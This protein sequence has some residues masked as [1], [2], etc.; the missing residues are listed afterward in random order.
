MLE[1][2]LKVTNTDSPED[3]VAIPLLCDW[4][5]A[6]VLFQ[7]S[8][9][10]GDAELV[11]VLMDEE[12]CNVQADAWA[13]KDDAW[14]E[15]RRRQ[16]GLNG[17][18]YPFF[19]PEARL[20]RLAKWDEVPAYSFC[21][22]LSLSALYKSWA[23]SFG[24]DY[25]EQGE[26]FE[27]LTE[28]SL[29]A[30]L[31]T[32]KIHR[33]GW[34]HSNT[35]NLRDIVDDVAARL[36]ES[37]GNVPKWTRPQAKEAGLDI[38][39]YRPYHDDRGSLPVYLMQCSSGRDFE[40]KLQTPDLKKWGRIVEFTST[41]RRAFATPRSFSEHDFSMHANSV[42][43]LFLDRYRLMAASLHDRHWMSDDLKRR[44]VR[45]LRPR[46]RTLPWE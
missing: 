11:D 1:F 29:R 20:R 21:L 12:I 37:V 18:S 28:Q 22:A 34:S 24:T 19:V 33:T 41:P 14:T 35:H 2:P 15:L 44:I 7:R 4:I 40:E 45:W 43:G 3:P 36:K 30:S 13:I 31:L 27:L 5:E 42:D 25:R 10:L 16:R 46:L 39:C 23:A 26:L 6:S 9:D 17:R 8:Q 32:W 38:L